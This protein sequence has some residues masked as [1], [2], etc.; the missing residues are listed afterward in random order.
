MNEPSSTTGFEAA[1][2][3]R[4]QQAYVLRLYVVGLTP[5]SQR[6]IMRLREICEQ[7]LAGRYQLEVIDI[8]LQPELAAEADIIAT[9]T[10]LR[11]L[12][13][14]VVRIVGDLADNHRVLV[15]LDLRPDE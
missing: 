12:P 15:G 7:H 4:A 14:P 5:A 3:D 8:H 1:L 13:E 2:R 6:A 9:P 10:L 11:L